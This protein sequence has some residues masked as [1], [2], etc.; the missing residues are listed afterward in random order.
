MVWVSSQASDLLA[1]PSI[2]TLSLSLNILQ[3]RKFVVR[4]FCGCVGVPILPLEVFLGQ[5][6]LLFRVICPLL[7]K[8]L[9]RVI[10]ICF[11]SLQFIPEIPTIIPD[12][13]PVSPS[14]QTSLL[15]TTELSCYPSPHCFLT[16]FPA[17][18]HSDDY[19][20]SPSQRGFSDLPLDPPCFLIPLG[21]WIIAWL[22]YT[23]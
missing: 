9:A 6:R 14:L 12:L 3:L 20:I 7:L 13:S 23:L 8:V 17:S 11:Q 10:L 4:M 5:R 2:P 18:V 22:T 21:L 16:Q 1:F 15:S 19:F